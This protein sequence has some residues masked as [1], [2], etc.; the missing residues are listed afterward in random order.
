MIRG[1]KNILPVSTL[2]LNLRGHESSP[3][4]YTF[5]KGYT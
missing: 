4:M 2:N 3:P 5:V 1:Y